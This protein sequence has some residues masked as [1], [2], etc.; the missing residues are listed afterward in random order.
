[1]CAGGGDV[2]GKLVCGE[3]APLDQHFEGDEQRVAGEGGDGGVG[4]GAVAD[5]VEREHLPESLLGGG[6][7]VG[8][9]EGRGAEVADAARGVERRDMKEKAGGAIERHSGTCRPG[10]RACGAFRWGGSL[11][12]P[13]FGFYFLNR[14]STY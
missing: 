12:S 7:E 8:E 14:E 6:E 1:M 13:L 3:P 4:R 10:N 5:G 11:W 9:G 2:L